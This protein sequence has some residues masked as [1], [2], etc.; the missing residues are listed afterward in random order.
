MVVAVVPATVKSSKKDEKV[1]AHLLDGTLLK[2]CAPGFYP[3]RAKF[4][5]VCEDGETHKIHIAELKALFFVHELAGHPTYRE[6]KGFLSEDSK[7]SKVLVEFFD[8]ELLFGHT[9]SYSPKGN[10]FFMSPGD[11]DSNNIRVFVV[12]SSTKRVKIRVADKPA[13]RSRKK[14]TRTKS[15]A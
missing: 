5:F 1:I 2:G 9:L 12:H 6:R 8:G 7:G 15:R 3:S 13:T 11:P 10:G 14:K 4:D